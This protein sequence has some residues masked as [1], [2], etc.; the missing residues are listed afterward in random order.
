[1]ISKKVIDQLYKQYNRRAQSIDQLNIPLLF[2]AVNPNHGIEFD[3]E[4]LV[5]N[6]VESD[7]PFHRIPMRGIHEIVEFEDVVAIVLHSSI[8]FLSRHADYPHPVQVHLKPLGM[9]L[10]QKLSSF[11]RKGVEECA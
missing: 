4:D 2:E 7:S 11:F 10:G 5:I 1:M 6:S 8:I 9:T 3:G